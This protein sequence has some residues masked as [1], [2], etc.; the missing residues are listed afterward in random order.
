ME[1]TVESRKAAPPRRQVVVYLDQRDEELLAEVTARTGLAKT[2]VFR[3]G[4]RRLATDELE[5]SRPGSSLAHLI[6]TA[7]DDALPADLSRR[8]DD[9]LYRDDPNCRE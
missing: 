1:A 8:H 5:G 9:H 6:A 2:E 3:R 7:R 4:L